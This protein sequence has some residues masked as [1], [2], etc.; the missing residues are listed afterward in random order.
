MRSEEA[1]KFYG[2]DLNINKM[3]VLIR[4]FQKSYSY[5][6]KPYLKKNEKE[7]IYLAV[8]DD[9]ASQI[10]S[11]SQEPDDDDREF[12]ENVLG[13]INKVV[14]D[15]QNTNYVVFKKKSRV[16]STETVI[17]CLFNEV[18]SLT[19]IAKKSTNYLPIT[20][21]DENIITST[22]MLNVFDFHKGILIL[23]YPTNENFYYIMTHSSNIVDDA[24]K[25]QYQA[26]DGE[27]LT[28]V[29]KN[30]FYKLASPVFF[31]KTDSSY[32]YSFNIIHEIKNNNLGGLLE[33]DRKD[34]A[35]A[36]YKTVTDKKSGNYE[37]TYIGSLRKFNDQRNK[38]NRLAELKNVLIQRFMQDPKYQG[39]PAS[40]I[41]DALDTLFAEYQDFFK[42][43]Q[44]QKLVKQKIKEDFNKKQSEDKTPE[45]IIQQLGKLNSTNDKLKIQAL[46][47]LL[48]D[49]YYNYKNPYTYI[50]SGRRRNIIDKLIQDLQVAEETTQKDLRQKLERKGKNI[51]TPEQIQSILINKKRGVPALLQEYEKNKKEIETLQEEIG[52]LKN[53]SNQ[54]GKQQKVETKSNQIARLRNKEN[55][56]IKAI[57]TKYKGLQDIQNQESLRNL[58]N[59][60]N[61]G[62]SIPYPSSGRQR[63][64]LLD[65]L[66]KNF[67]P[68]GGTPEGIKQSINKYFN[69][70]MTQSQKRNMLKEKLKKDEQSENLNYLISELEGVENKGTSLMINLSDA[71]KQ[72][73]PPSKEKKKHIEEL[74]RNLS[75]NQVKKQAL[76][77]LINEKEFDNSLTQLD[78]LKKL[79]KIKNGPF[80]TNILGKKDDAIQNALVEL[81]KKQLL[82]GD[83]VNQKIRNLLNNSRRKQQYQEKALL[84]A[85][86]AKLGTQDGYKNIFSNLSD[87]EKGKLQKEL[88]R[89]AEKHP[90]KVSESINL[91]EKVDKLRKDYPSAATELA[92]TIGTNLATIPDA[93]SSGVASIGTNLATIPDAISSGVSSIGN[94]LNKRLRRPYNDDKE[95]DFDNQNASLLNNTTGNDNNIGGNNLKEVDGKIYRVLTDFD[96]SG[97][98]YQVLVDDDGKM[99]SLNDDEEL[100]EVISDNL[101]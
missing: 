51:L 94:A 26:K 57:N 37:N 29:Y 44:I 66:K 18:P 32:K 35:D 76:L 63:K 72:K 75:L 15:N 84:Q 54:Q 82:T 48:N 99:Y 55:K 5:G 2:Q 101:L 89:I 67:T 4:K 28:Y 30:R 19:L 24:N 36:Y 21:Q 56:L 96:M 50:E 97:K 90:V 69:K 1:K 86:I 34:F 92:T 79:R 3:Y 27:N 61:M 45:K 88:L 9:E 87:G 43:G 20:G 42:E 73:T 39:Q 17:P 62:S 49:T 46:N 95:D 38:K 78:K 8:C 98:S 47:Q 41:K 25:I 11:I 91:K 40:Q 71:S 59:I 52:N 80:Y 85:V 33:S 6:I 64:Q 16:G 22:G 13:K 65:K 7:R 70:T 31:N 53:S 81:E 83:D 77:Q 14:K 58:Y 23:K 10:S 68:T 100:Q 93:I 74:K 12:F 60:R